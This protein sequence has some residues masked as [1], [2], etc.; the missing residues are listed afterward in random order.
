MCPAKRQ[1]D[2][3]GGPVPFLKNVVAG[4]SI[5]LNHAAKAFQVLGD[6]LA[7]AAVGININHQRRRRPDPWSVIDRITP[8]KAR[9]GL[10]IAWLEHR[11]LGLVGEDLAACKH[12]LHEMVVDRLQPPAGLADPA[13]QR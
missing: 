8:K 6:M 3:P 7:A 13:R 4:I 2:R 9:L 1:L 11:H 5:H 12:A 10:A